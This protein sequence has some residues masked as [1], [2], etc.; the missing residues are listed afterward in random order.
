MLATAIENTIPVLGNWLLGNEYGF[1]TDCADYDHFA[2]LPNAA[3]LD[4]RTY[5]KT[6]WNSD[7]GRAYYKTG[8]PVAR[9]L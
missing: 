3:E 1:E 4:G 7:R 5:V 8:R 2:A 6:G 9:A